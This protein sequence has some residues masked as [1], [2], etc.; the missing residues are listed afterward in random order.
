MSGLSVHKL[1]GMWE[2][3]ALAVNVSVTA[4]EKITA[5]SKAQREEGR[6]E[7]L[8]VA[9]Q[10]HLQLHHLM[11]YL[12]KRQPFSY[13]QHEQRMSRRHKFCNK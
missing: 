2:L 7:P 12:M 6:A 11:L 5:I 13:S 9:A 4:S 1:Y 8:T 10:C 3:L